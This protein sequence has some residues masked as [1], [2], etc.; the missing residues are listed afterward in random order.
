MADWLERIYRQEKDPSVNEFG[1][2]YY[3]VFREKKKRGELN[4]EDK[5]AYD[6]D[7]GS[8]LDHE[9]NN[10]FKLGQRLCCGQVGSY[11][12]ILHSGM[13]S[14][15]LTRSLVS[16]ERI[17]NG[18][19]KVLE[20]DFSAFH[21]E[22]VYNQPGSG[23]SKELIMKPV[24]P[25]II[26]VPTYGSRAVMWQELTGRVRSTPARFIFPVFTADNLDNMIIEIMAKFRWELSRTMSS[27]SR[28]NETGPSSLVNDYINYIQFYKKNRDLSGEAREKVR[29]QVE[30]YRNNVAEIFAS[31][32]NTWINFESKGLVRLNKVAREILFRH[33]PFSQNIRTQLQ[34]H[35]LYNQ[36]ISRY[37]TQRGK[38]VKFLQAH[39]AKL[40]SDGVVS[41]PD[42]NH[43][44]MYYNL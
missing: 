36:L 25:E 40:T 8:R 7:S 18:I 20:V 9:T 39:Y 10:L 6:G 15:D 34:S 31:D 16:P 22:I 13:I 19:N 21:R 42:L 3:E 29:V 11:F 2:D 26:L 43:N 30:K 17:Q 32:Y 14:Y 4:E 37:E 41:D 35:P 1:Q 12:P 33:C 44:L 23:I 24:W 27:Y 38:Q 5:F 28:N